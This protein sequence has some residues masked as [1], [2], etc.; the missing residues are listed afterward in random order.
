MSPLKVAI[1]GANGRVSKILIDNLLA[2]YK[3]QYTPIAVIRNPEHEQYFSSINVETRLADLTGDEVAIVD[4]I[5]GV[6]AVILTAGTPHG[7]APGPE[8]VDHQGTRKV[9]SVLKRLGVKRLIAI[10]GLRADEPELFENH[11]LK[12]YYIARK[13]ADDLIR[14][15]DGIEYTVLRPGWFNNEPGTA[16]VLDVKSEAD[17]DLETMIGSYITREDVVQAIIEVLNSND[18]I[19]KVIPL[20]NGEDKSLKDYINNYAAA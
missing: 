13:Q 3:D 17:L 16:K 14:A 20:L 6:D 4:A 18:S 8:L 11:F 7:V 19:N 10:S 15:A 2:N 5:T 12:D 9:L 1:F